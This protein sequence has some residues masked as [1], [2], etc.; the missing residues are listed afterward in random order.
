MRPYN[1]GAG[2]TAL[3]AAVLEEAQEGLRDW[4]GTGQSVMELSFTGEAYQEIYHDCVGTLRRLLKLPEGYQILLMQ[5]GAY[6][7]FSILPMNL[8]GKCNEADYA[9][10][11]HWSQRAAKEAAKYGRV[12]R[13]NPE[14]QN[15]ENDRSEF[16]CISQSETWRLNPNAAYCHITT[17]ETANGLQFKSIPKTGD[18]P[19]IADMTSDFLIAPLRSIRVWCG[20]CVGAKEWGNSRID[21]GDHRRRLA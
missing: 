19:L 7:Q 14:S 18:V 2:P 15:C 4:K 5:G 1:F 12:T 6:G 9:V 3:P 13:V 17:N 20:L 16:N 11:G 8:M 21:H 10:T